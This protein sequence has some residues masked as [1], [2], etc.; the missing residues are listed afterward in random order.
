MRLCASQRLWAPREEVE[1]MRL[2]EPFGVEGVAPLLHRLWPQGTRLHD[3]LIAAKQ[4]ASSVRDGGMEVP[5]VLDPVDS[6]DGGLI[7]PRAASLFSRIHGALAVASEIGAHTVVLGAPG[8]RRHAL[9][10]C[11]HDEYDLLMARLVASA[12]LA[13]QLGVVLAIKPVPVT[14]GGRFWTNLAQVQALCESIGSVALQPALDAASL[15]R[16]RDPRGAL[17]TYAGG[18]SVFVAS[19][20]GGGPLV[21]DHR[22]I[23]RQC[24]PDLARCG[25]VGRAPAWLVWEGDGPDVARQAG[26]V[27]R[28]QAHTVRCLYAE[29]LQSACGSAQAPV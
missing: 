18:A 29:A 21:G 19:E 16:E 25:R 24:A 28:A 5:V 10:P 8:L 1:V 17:T 20:S 14:S 7:G 6:R 26:P 12:G 13:E 4:W 27:L 9:P 15:A 23:H 11:E 22:T 2:L 3:G